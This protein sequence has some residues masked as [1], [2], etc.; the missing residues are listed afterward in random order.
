MREGLLELP[1]E[2]DDTVADTSLHEE[3]DDESVEEALIAGKARVLGYESSYEKASHF[4]VTTH[5]HSSDVPCEVV[6]KV[7][8]EEEDDYKTKNVKNNKNMQETDTATKGSDRRHSRAIG[9]VKLQSLEPARAVKYFGPAARHGFFKAMRQVVHHRSLTDV[10][11]DGREF[12]DKLIKAKVGDNPF[13]RSYAELQLLDVISPRREPEDALDGASIVQPT[14]PPTSSTKVKDAID[15][16]GKGAGSKSRHER[17]HLKTMRQLSGINQDTLNRS[18]ASIDLIDDHERHD[19]VKAAAESMALHASLERDEDCHLDADGTPQYYDPQSPRAEFVAHCLADGVLPLSKAVLRK[20]LSTTL[21]VHGQ[22]MGPKRILGLVDAMQNL[23]FLRVINFRGNRL[24]DKVLEAVVLAVKKMPNIVDLDLGENDVGDDSSAALGNLLS[25]KWC[26]LRRLSLKGAGVTDTE[27]VAWV[28]ALI[29]NKHN[30]LEHLDLSEN[31]IGGSEIENVINP[32]LLTGGEV[33]A[34]FV[35][36]P[37]CQLKNLDLSWNVIRLKGCSDL[38]CAMGKNQSLQH[39]NLAHNALRTQGGI[40]L[41]AALLKNQSIRELNITNCGIDDRAMTTIGVAARSHKSLKRLVINDNH[42]GE[43]GCRIAVDLMQWTSH[44]EIEMKSCNVM[45]ASSPLKH[46]RYNR[47]EPL[48]QYELNLSDPYSRALVLDMMSMSAHHSSVLMRPFEYSADEGRTWETITLKKRMKRKNIEEGSHD[49][50]EEQAELEKINLSNNKEKIKELFAEIDVDKGGFLDEV[51][52]GLLLE[53]LG[54]QLKPSAVTSIMKAVDMDAEGV[55]EYDEVEEYVR[56]LGIQAQSRLFS[57]T[58]EMFLVRDKQK[59]LDIPY[60]T[61]LP[62]KGVVKFS[63]RESFGERRSIALSNIQYRHIHRVTGTVNNK[64]KVLDAICDMNVINLNEARH[65]FSAARVEGLSII[66]ACV[67]ILPS[68]IPIRARSVFLSICTGNEEA[69][70]AK[71][72]L[73]LGKAFNVLM[74]DF[75]GYYI[76]DFSKEMDRLCMAKLLEQS[77]AYNCDRI[78]QDLGDLSQHGTWSCFRNECFKGERTMINSTTFNPLPSDGVVEFDFVGTARPEMHLISASRDASL[79]NKLV[80]LGLL[81]LENKRPALRLLASLKTRYEDV[82]MEGSGIL[83][84]EFTQSFMNDVQDYMTYEFYEHLEDRLPA[85]QKAETVEGMAPIVNPWKR[86]RSEGKFEFGKIEGTDEHRH[87]VHSV[88]S[89]HNDQNGTVAALLD[90]KNQARR[91]AAAKTREETYEEHEQAEKDAEAPFKDQDSPPRV[92][93]SEG[94]S[95]S[96]ANAAD[97]GSLN[98]ASLAE[99]SVIELDK[100]M[101]G[102]VS[103]GSLEGEQRMHAHMRACIEMVGG[104]CRTVARKWLTCRQLALILQLF[105]LGELERTKWGSY[106]VVLICEVLSKVIDIHNFKVVLM[107]LTAKEYACVTCRIGILNTFNPWAPEGRLKLD[108][109]RHE[110]RVVAKMLIHLSI[111]EPGNNTEGSGFASDIKDVELGGWIVNVNWFTEEG[112]GSHGWLNLKYT[113]GNGD[114]KGGFKPNHMLRAALMCHVLASHLEI[115]KVAN[116]TSNLVLVEKL[117]KKAGL[118][119]LYRGQGHENW[120]NNTLIPL[121]DISII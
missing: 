70:M 47:A 75:D 81:S 109:S 89:R 88:T 72:R 50:L 40:E 11:H 74:G 19:A 64:V 67:M 18:L 96:G 22:N 115:P 79:C 113:S 69:I 117:K 77:V 37:T 51:E 8:E 46:L 54:L 9:G 3:S 32:E 91:E 108:L 6:L 73:K 102:E 15:M 83:P 42:I 94:D 119:F 27:C 93:R 26:K 110:E 65:I 66:S 28:R 17:H 33:L 1:D 92:Q 48:G 7:E 52:F 20:E 13:V 78:A 25:S 120:D 111:I 31:T 84:F 68:I 90:Q 55:V 53:R 4:T 21:D 60:Y 43:E 30:Q 87:H 76:L 97:D 14:D 112:F 98:S 2:P 16:P 58:M 62:E 45:D 71:I 63:M 80:R 107:Q 85:V 24:G 12:S 118:S 86:T 114:G 34:L 5:A 57:V 10:K 38:L 23:P 116:E 44:I 100:P 101:E 105:K 104:I 49:W 39:V 36:S 61:L 35:E 82:T 99:S 29:K 41:G 59:E 95:P 121:D 56:S 106:R 103:E